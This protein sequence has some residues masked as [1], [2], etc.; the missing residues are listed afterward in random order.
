MKQSKNLVIIHDAKTG[1]YEINELKYQ[2]GNEYTPGLSTIIIAPVYKKIL[3]TKDNPLMPT[4]IS[5]GWSGYI[6]FG[7]RLLANKISRS[8]KYYFSEVTR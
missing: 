5:P 8:I 4:L 7:L 1:A 2:L 6:L 3:V